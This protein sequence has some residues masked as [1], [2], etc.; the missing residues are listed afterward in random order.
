M[1]SRF[2][3][4]PVLAIVIA[5]V[6]V[7]MG[8]LSINKLPVSQF[9]EIAPTTVN[10]FIAY[11]GSSAE[12]LVNSTLIPLETA[13][14]GVQDMRYIAS[15]ATSA[16]EATIRI[17][18]E[19]GT[20]PNEAVVR[21]KTRV[22]QVMPLL[23]ELVQREGVIITPVQPSMLMYVNLFSDADKNDE[24]F[25]YNYSYTKIIPEIQRI[26]GI[27]SA[28]I[29]GSR[30]YA[31]RVWLKPDRMRAYNISA[32]E[33][34]QAM[35]EQSVIAR[36][37]RIGQSSGIEAQSLEYVLTYEGRYNKEEQYKE[38][39]IK[40][41]SEG[42][43]L[44]LKDIAEVEL[45]SE[46]FDIYSNLDGKPSA[47]IVLKQTLGSNASEVIQ[48]VKDKLKEFETELPPGVAYKISYDV[49]NFLDASIEQVIHTLR[50]AFILV[51]IVVFL[52]L[53]D[54]RSTLI[55]IIAVPI[56]LIGAFFVMQLFGLSINL[57]T[58]FALVLAIGIVVDDA[59]VVVEAVHEKM[60][61]EHLSPYKAVKKVIKEIGGAIIAIT[62]VMV[63]VF[64]PISF[65]S[66][67]V[68]VFYRQFS[69][70]MIGAI[71]I[72]AI[73][74]LTLTPVLCAM[75]LKDNHGKPRKKSLV[76]KFID[77]F[78][79]RFEKLTG[80]YIKLLR[81]IVNRRVITFSILIVFC[82][83]IFF[84]NEVLPSGF[85]PNEDQGTIYA[86]IQTPPG[87]TLERTNDVAQKLQ[88]LC[89][90]V[91]GI[92]S[93]SSL[94]GY[95]IMTEGRGSNAG[96]CLINLKSWSEREHSVHE[97]ME[98]L[99]EKSEGLGAVIEYFEPP[100]VPGFGSSGGFA[101]RLLD[102]N[103]STDYQEFDKVNKNFMTA[104]S[105]REE[106]TGVFTFFAANYPQI[107]LKINN[108][109]AMQKGV[110]IGKAMENLNILIG[111]T[112]EQGFIRFGRFFKVYT[113]AGPEYRRLPSDLE[114]LY[115]KNDTGEMVPYSS[116]MTLEKKLGPNEITRYN[117]YNSASINGLPAEGFTSGDAIKAIQEVAE[118]TLPRG[119][120]IAWEG[121][122]YDEAGRGSESIYIFGIV[123][124][125]VYLV[126]A[127]QYESFLLPLAVIL[128]L[129][130]GIFGSF[131]LLKF[132][133]LAN[134]IYAQ[135]GLI[136]LV[137]LLGKNAVLI[138]EFAVQKRDQGATIFEA[139]IQGAKMRFRPILMTSFAFIA[140]LIP[141]VLASGAG[142]I[143]N[144]TIGASAMGGMLL[145]TLLGV[146]V[147]PGLY[148]IFATMADGRGLIKNETRV[149]VSEEYYKYSEEGDTT[150]KELS[151]LR[152]LINKLGLKSTTDKE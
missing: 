77:G 110:S 40:A 67:P 71:S 126:L 114:K 38:I 82:V 85:I 151:R 4:R 62:L 115:V 137:G 120:D 108:E 34:L 76:D 74:A 121:L 45:G 116:F 13:I 68:G 42:E 56:S 49:S 127:A 152:K 84:T 144:R 93:V 51:A 73:V 10:I 92:E 96:T 70:T 104:L 140:G 47:S 111:S 69:I 23:P 90:E 46:F 81:L 105:K 21:V 53:G 113:Q 147:I 148:Y 63:A 117:L 95:E 98:E 19:P 145:G 36:P 59:I 28:Q 78:N 15:D 12:V 149:T 30:K 134:D 135:I 52:F 25:L 86:I 9:P 55:P 43:I 1:F 32:E 101:M 130:V 109:A 146:I 79:S 26:E 60:E 14:N 100:A 33:V 75:I 128:S 6:I 54:W 142:A 103:N 132:M 18:F 88:K 7:F 41:N 107:D 31:M 133:G 66:G 112:Y 22:D 65:M 35:D 58:L 80:R 150:R 37:G 118:E 16:G 64:I 8:L 125:F 106:L 11:P 91:D 138:V 129:P 24:K 5:I 143:A 94:A 57:I 20:D 89:L 136:M 3:K 141:L 29:L 17:I 72:S 123:L 48:K 2:L 139:A 119:Y 27:A 61:E 39:I 44:K 99:E 83:G 102:K 50:D 87:A 97:I 124:L 122:S 131:L